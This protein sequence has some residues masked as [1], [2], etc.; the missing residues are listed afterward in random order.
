MKAGQSSESKAIFGNYS[1]SPQFVGFARFVQ[2]SNLDC[3]LAAWI[4]FPSAAKV[5][6]SLAKKA[7][8]GVLRVW[9]VNE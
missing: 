3:H 6:G 4:M 8:I 2:I 1:P 7:G 5:A 9:R